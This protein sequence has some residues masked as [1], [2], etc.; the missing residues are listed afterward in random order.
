MKKQVQK[1]KDRGR[2]DIEATEETAA[3]WQNVR[4][5][6]SENLGETKSQGT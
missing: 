5:T 2:T 3:R 1:C 6:E 4:S